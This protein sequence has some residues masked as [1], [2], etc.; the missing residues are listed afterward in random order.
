MTNLV[1]L[2][3]EIKDELEDIFTGFHVTT[4]PVIDS[5]VQQFPVIF[6]TLGQQGVTVL[7]DNPVYRFSAQFV[8]EF[9]KVLEN[10]EDLIPDLEPLQVD[11]IENMFKGVGSIDRK[12][13]RELGQ[14]IFALQED[15]LGVLSIE[16]FAF[17]HRSF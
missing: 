15:N 13:N 2:Q 12:K 3:N 4:N 7:A 16:I 9:W 1:A 11:F 14:S 17:Y 10:N 5:S 8:V 6:I